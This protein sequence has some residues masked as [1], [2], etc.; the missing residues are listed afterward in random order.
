MS[1]IHILHLD[2]SE[3]DIFYKNIFTILRHSPRTRTE[4]APWF[5]TPRWPGAGRSKPDGKDG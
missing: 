3:S 5:G 1:I 2:Q 4:A